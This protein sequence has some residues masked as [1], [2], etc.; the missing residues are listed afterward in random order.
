MS[1]NFKTSAPAHAGRFASARKH[2]PKANPLADEVKKAVDRAQRGIA[3]A[4]K[5]VAQSKQVMAETDKALRRAKDLL[6]KRASG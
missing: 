6:F 5:T 4:K 3:Q 1:P 2:G